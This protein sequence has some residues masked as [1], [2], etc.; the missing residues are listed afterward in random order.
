MFMILRGLTL[1]AC[2]GMSQTIAAQTGGAAQVY[3][4]QLKDRLAFERGY[5][6]H[7]EWHAREGDQLVWYGWYVVSGERTGA[8]VDGTF[9]ATVDALANRIEPKND[10][11]D[12]KANAASYAQALGNEVWQLWPEAS[13]ARTLEQRR[14]TQ[15]IEVY[16][17]EVKNSVD[18][19]STVL[20]RPTHGVAWYRAPGRPNAYLL[21]GSEPAK[22]RG[23]ELDKLLGRDHPA[24][25]ESRAI[26]SEIWEYEKNLTRFP[27]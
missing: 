5:R 17:I 27:E 9:G 11:A 26:R 25:R 23:A 15:R 8:F 2:L 6:K 7:L 14:P 18:F 1:L 12:F 24:L 4:Y 21:I 3:V 16:L 20:E 22:S 13:S 10:A 19:E